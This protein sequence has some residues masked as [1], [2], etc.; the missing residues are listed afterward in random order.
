M[1]LNE[2]AKIGSK[3]N[4]KISTIKFY[5][6]EE[7]EEEEEELNKDGI[8]KALNSNLP[9]LTPLYP[10]IKDISYFDEN[11]T[12]TKILKLSEELPSLR[13]DNISLEEYQKQKQKNNFSDKFFTGFSKSPM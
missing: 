1:S 13:K 9:S 4:I 10:G 5:D 11:S 2:N 7:E 12:N 6:E 8:D 3:K